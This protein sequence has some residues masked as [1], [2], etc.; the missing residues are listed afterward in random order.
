MSTMSPEAETNK[1]ANTSDKSTN[2]ENKQTTMAK[3][4]TAEV[5]STLTTSKKLENTKP[6]DKKITKKVTGGDDK[7]EASGLATNHFLSIIA[8]AAMFVPFFLNA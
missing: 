8:S 4:S 3:F 2:S 6:A 7:D 5:K 1:N